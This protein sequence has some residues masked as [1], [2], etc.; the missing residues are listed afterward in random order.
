MTSRDK[1]GGAFKAFRFS[2]WF[3]NELKYGNE[4]LFQN[5]DG[6]FASEF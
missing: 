1:D 6:C 5:P 4:E 3:V 2:S